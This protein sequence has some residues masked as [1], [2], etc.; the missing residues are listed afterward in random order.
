[1]RF[2]VL[3]S[4]H[5]GLRR[6]FLFSTLAACSSSSP[7][8]GEPTSQPSTSAST[9][10]SAAASH[11]DDSMSVL[12]TLRPAKLVLD[13][14]VE[15][16]GSLDA[17]P[18]ALAS[19]PAPWQSAPFGMSYLKLELAQS[20]PNPEH[21]SSKVGV[22]LDGA[23]VVVAATLAEPAKD[24]LWLALGSAVPPLPRIGFAGRGGYVSDLDCEHEQICCNDGYIER[25][26]ELTPEASA[27]CHALLERD[28]QAR[29]DFADEFV[30]V[31]R[32]DAAG[33]SLRGAD[34]A[35]TPI[36]GAQ[37]AFGKTGASGSLEASIPLT[38]LPRFS[39]APITTLA[40]LVRPLSRPKDLAATVV[41][42]RPWVWLNLPER[43]S[44]EPLSVL[45]ETTYAN[46]DGA[47]FFNPAMSYSAADPTH[48]RYYQHGGS[49]TDLVAHE[50]DL[51][52]KLDSF[53][54]V[55]VGML[56]VP[57]NRLV[58]LKA[59]K[60]IA[61]TR[62]YSDSHLDV[63]PSIELAFRG[64]RGG[65]HHYLAFLPTL[66]DPN[67]GPIQATWWLTIVGPDGE[68]DGE[69][70]RVP[71][72]T[73]MFAFDGESFSNK[74]FTEF[75]VGGTLFSPDEPRPSGELKWNWDEKKGVYTPKF[76]VLKNK[77]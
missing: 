15:E 6:L 46:T 1:M 3:S 70:L 25:G 12:A 49:A 71:D 62:F 64:V 16:W 44:F 59:G 19:E 7:H 4:S 30:R 66:W 14:S 28:Q 76:K 41:R 50:A 52:T 26:P 32:I 43:V 63:A 75:G 39:Q 74:D 68:V 53:G 55:E 69:A 67:L 18:A 57:S 20:A 38:A 21:A 31:Y 10:S 24:G 45:R 11:A 77:R 73:P 48:L 36:A 34:G 27:A 33:V 47:T 2:W 8:A 54:D 51:Y 61:V 9:S 42:E 58:V 60:P 22:A 23:G 13:G 29:A 65:K 17:D 40:Y 72:D 35:L 37:V 5:L 56:H